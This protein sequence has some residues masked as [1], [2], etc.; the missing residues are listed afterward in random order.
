M[1]TK[2]DICRETRYQIEIVKTADRFAELR[3]AWERLVDRAGVSDYYSTHRWLQL[4]VEYFHPRS[5]HMLVLWD[6]DQI[7]S[8]IPMVRNVFNY[9][10]L[11]IR[12]L[13]LTRDWYAPISALLTTRNR[14]EEIGIL[15]RHL[16]SPA[17][18]WDI[19]DLDGLPPENRATEVLLSQISWLG[20]PC[21]EEEAFGNWIITGFRSWDD[22]WESRH[23]RLK[24]ASL[25]HRKRLEEL[26][27]VRTRIISNGEG[28]GLLFHQF[29]DVCERSWKKGVEQ[30]P[31]FLQ[32]TM[33]LASER[34]DFRIA[35]LELNGEAIATWYA[36]IHGSTA[37]IPRTAYDAR[38]RPYMP[39]LLLL[40]DF[41]RYLMKAD[42][43]QTID[44]QHGD[45]PYKSLWANER[46][47]RKRVVA[48]NPRSWKGHLYV[49]AEYRHKPKLK[50]TPA[51]RALRCA[52][53]KMS[54]FPLFR[55]FRNAD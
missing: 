21:H 15:L 36:F 25:R 27:E 44:H 51:W 1:G 26:G 18:R 4:W 9:H 42:G 32:S 29:H 52:R 5:A 24:R 50:A 17:H 20:W 54:A 43:V 33:R 53:D 11:R 40:E 34:G 37:Y 23:K 30:H 14:E 3:S 38:F 10:G 31:E 28:I 2:G 48:A 12:R 39:G 47:L 49:R 8:S 35:F 16:A 45:E 7:V 13:A 41:Q 46:R 55:A 22:Y 6:H 19:L